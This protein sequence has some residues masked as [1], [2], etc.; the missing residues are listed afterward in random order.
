MELVSTAEVSDLFFPATPTSLNCETDMI[1]KTQ[2][3]IFAAMVLSCS[4]SYGQVFTTISPS[5]LGLNQGDTFSGQQTFNI[6][7]QFGQSASAVQLLI[8]NG[9]VASTQDLFT[10]GQG[11]SVGFTI[12]SSIP[13]EAFVQ[14][15][16][17]LGSQSAQSGTGVSDGLTAFGGEQ[18]TLVS[19]LDSD[20]S[21]SVTPNA[22]G[23]VTYAVTYIGPDTGNVESNSSA[24]RFVSNEPVSG[25][26]VFSN[27]TTELA[28]NFS[29]GFRAAAAVP[30]PSSTALLAMASTV[31]F[32]RRRRR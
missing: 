30:E 15:G 31:L 8:N 11:S 26:N 19:P 18:F 28:N 23:S 29:I 5:S 20:F 1:K 6:G 17:V 12:N 24:F 32:V 13:L 9:N 16:G 3:T 14:H 22:S 25:F 7:T 10:T 2:L 21:S 27:N 4:M